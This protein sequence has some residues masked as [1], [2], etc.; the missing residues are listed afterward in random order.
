M[1]KTLSEIVIKVE[2]LSKKYG[3]FEAVKGVSF[4]VKKGEI[5]GLIGPDGAGKTSVIQML[6]GVASFT[7]GE[8]SITGLKVSKH[9]EKIKEFIGY[10]PQGLGTN[11]YDN[12]TVEENINFFKALRLIPQGIFEKNKE[13][14]L[15][16]TRLKPF[17]KRPVKTLSGGMRQ[18]L[19]LICT[20]L[21]LP[22]ILLLDEPTTGV[23]P[24]SRQDFWK[25]IHN[26]VKEKEITVL[27][28]TSYMDEAERC[29]KIALMH[30]GVILLEDYPEK[31]I[32]LEDTF[33]EKITGKK[34]EKD[35]KEKIYSKDLNKEPVVICKEVSKTFGS[36]IA[37]N[38]VNLEIIKGEI[39]GLLGPNGA[40]KTTLIKMMCGLLEPTEGKI[41]VNGLDVIRE[42]TKIW[43]TV[44][45]MSQRFS[46][47]KDLTVLENLK[48][49][50]NLYQVKNLN[51]KE[52]LDFLGLTEFK[53]R[54]VRDLPFGIRQRIALAC[55]LLH[56]P[57]IVFLDEP[58]SGVDPVARK[59]FWE[60][61]YEVSR[62]RGITVIV[63]THYMDEAEH[64][65]RVAFMNRGKIVALGTPEEIKEQSE[66]NSGFLLEIRSAQYKKALDL[67]SQS[68]SEF[69]VYGRKIYV[70]TF[71]L[72]ETEDKIKNLFQ[73][74][75]LSLE[76][77]K[78][79]PIPLQEAFVDFI[80]RT[81][82]HEF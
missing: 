50:A 55:A 1:D 35:K 7:S 77:V 43:E 3:S 80:K 42:K 71:N 62:K 49:Y 6:A 46:L 5:F 53:D 4:E 56:E 9:A 64:C 73:A 13:L 28:T 82:E 75:K 36:F 81:E 2:N 37:V 78:K 18:K 8:A 63:S 11:L 65:D 22:D 44:G 20:L 10:M 16:I 41:L 58:T 72:K 17:L 47:Y 21:H 24:I 40:G 52:S 33:I 25:I 29:H 74:N 26:F 51:L 23:D 15:E 70:R 57:K 27:L 19:A 54:V 76:S 67:I 59:I 60:I 61:I 39:F 12:L 45:Y 69:S 68:F 66:K 14:L 31:I 79:I 34:W 30:E 48:L 38:R 32:D